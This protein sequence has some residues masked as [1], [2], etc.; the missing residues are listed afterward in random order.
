MKFAARF[1]IVL[2]CATGALEAQP[3]DIDV[4]LRGHQHPVQLDSIAIWNVIPAPQARTFT[5]VRHVLAELGVPFTSA[6]SVSGVFYKSPFTTSRQILGKRMS[7][8][9]SCGHGL[10]GPNADSY[11]IHMAYAI[12][13]EPTDGQQTRV[14]VALAS[15]ANTTEGTSTRPVPCA[16]TGALEQEIAMR[17][18]A[19]AQVRE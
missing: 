6:D 7:W 10:T 8:A 15:G 3:R 4:R 19:R 11:R 1:A 14:G 9:M 5:A 18:R 2:L 12:F 17:V 13:L 16:S